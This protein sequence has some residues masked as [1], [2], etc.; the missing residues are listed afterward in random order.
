MNIQKYLNTRKKIVDDALEKFLPKRG[1]YPS[2]IHKSIRYSVFA[3]G[4]RIRP[5]LVL[6]SA[7][8]LG[9]SYKRVLPTACAIELIHTYSLIHD[10]LP[11]MDNDDYRRGMLTNHKVFGESIA[12][13]SGDALLTHSF[14]LISKNKEI[15]G[16]K[17]ENVL[18]VIN[19]ISKA[20][21]TFGLIGGQVVD[22]LSEGKKVSKSKLKYIHT[23]KTGALI[24]A[25]LQAG[26]IL[27]DAKDKEYNALT[28]YGKNLGLLF[29]I[30]DDM[31]NVTGDAKKLGKSVGS[32][33][34][35]KKI[36]Y[37]SLFGIKKSKEEIQKLREKAKRE[38]SIFK[39]KKNLLCEL[40]DFIIE[41]EY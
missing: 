2:I 19:I 37:P 14:E 5:I 13:L 31:L 6:L 3:G 32:D 40:V 22:I 27:S 20:C 9:K 30:V 8:T 18:K 12:T 24:C 21:G 10:D 17:P 15:N 25:S 28:K 11:C 38:V 7:E 39:T 23:H 35:R 41:R 1:K 26:A 4:K 36:T 16:V 34:K 33:A 29:Q